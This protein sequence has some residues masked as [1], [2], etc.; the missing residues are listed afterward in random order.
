MEDRLRAEE[1]ME[2]WRLTN[3]PE[4]GTWLDARRVKAGATVRVRRRNRPAVRSA[5]HRRNGS[6]SRRASQFPC[7]RNRP[8]GG[9][10]LQERGSMSAIIFAR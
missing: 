10:D 5:L 3:S 4:P 2:L 9:E 6:A 7:V 8:A 1:G